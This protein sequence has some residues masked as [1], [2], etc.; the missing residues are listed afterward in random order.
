V[1]DASIINLG[2]LSKP[3]TVLVEKISEAVGGVFKPYQIVRVAKAQAEAEKIQ[4]QA[5][6]EITDLQ[7]RAMQRFFEEEGKRQ[8]NIE[9]ITQ[10]AL[11]LLKEESKPQDV[12]DDWITNFF[13]KCRVI[14]DPEMQQLWFKILAG[15]ANSPG[16]FSRRTVNLLS[17]LEKRDAE[18]F[19]SLCGFGWNYEEPSSLLYPLVFDVDNEIYTQRDIYY[20]NLAHLESLGL[21]QF[22]NFLGF[23]LTRRPKQAILSYFGSRVQLTLPNDENNKLGLGKVLLTHAG[24]ELTRVCKPKLVEGF[25][26]YAIKHWEEEKL[27]PKVCEVK[28]NSSPNLI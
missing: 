26:E 8:A 25:L 23:I 20:S 11:P 27:T 16:S 2:K 13:D 17:D 5:K 6:I 15:E 14:S 28:E 19:Q 7:H 18:L 12:E 22:D 21:V 4:A 24:Q 3:A 10:K 9:D 1:P